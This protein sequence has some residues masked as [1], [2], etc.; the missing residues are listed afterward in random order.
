[1]TSITHGQPTDPCWI[2]DRDRVLI[3]TTDALHDRADIDDHLWQLIRT[4][5]SVQQSLDLFMLAG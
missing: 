1:M 3:E 2:D 5:L 4:H